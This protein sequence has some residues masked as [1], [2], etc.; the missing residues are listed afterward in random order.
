MWLLSGRINDL[1]VRDTQELTFS[2]L[3]EESVRTEASASQEERH[4]QDLNSLE[5]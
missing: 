3:C 2:L 5:N 1:I 4:H